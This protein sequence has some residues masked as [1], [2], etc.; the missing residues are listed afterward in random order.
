M[1][2]KV[3]LLSSTENDGKGKPEE[4]VRIV[5]DG[6]RIINIKKDPSK[7]NTNLSELIAFICSYCI[8]KEQ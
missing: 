1:T 5:K 2:I 4:D 7:Y 6:S 3:S 8:S